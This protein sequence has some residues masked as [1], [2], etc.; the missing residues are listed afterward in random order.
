MPTPEVRPYGSWQSPITTGLIVSEA[1]ALGQIALDG[2][3]IY[4]AEM[5]PSE[6]GRNVI[7]HRT[8]DGRTFDATL[9]PFNVRTRVHEY[10]GG[11][12]TVH[13]GAI[14][15]SNFS[16]QL[17]YRQ[18]PGQTPVPIT[19]EPGIRH[20]DYVFDPARA[21]ILCVQE[22]Y[23]TGATEPVNSIAALDPLGQS[24][25]QTLVSGNDFYA[26]PRLSPD[27][28]RLAWI[29]WDHPNMPW[30][31]TQLWTA[32][33]LPDGSLGP[34]SLI[35]G[36]PTESI[37][38]P[39]WSPDGHLHFVS[40][41]TGWWNLY[42]QT[43]AGVQPLAPMQAEFGKPQWALG[44]R[45]YGFDSAGQIVC[46]YNQKG[47]WQLA[48]LDPAT[49]RVAP[50]DLP[51]QETGRGDLKVAGNR[52]VFEAGS[53]SQPMSLLSLD[54]STQELQI[55][56]TAASLTVDPSYFSYPESIEF[57]TEDGLTA[58]AFYY[59]PHNPSFTAPTGEKPPLL[60]KSHGGPTSATSTALDLAIQFWTS[61]GF[62]I[63]DVNYGGSSGYG[64][65]YR[66]RL[67]GRW[68]IVDVD[69]C[70]NAARH[71]VT[72]GL[73][74]PNRLAIDGGSA[75]GYT[76]LAALTFRDVFSAGASYYGVSDLE[77]LARD[78]HKFE[79]RYLDTLIGPYPERQ[80]LYQAR[81]PINFTGRMSCPIILFQGSEDRIVPPDQAQS[82]YQAV[83]AKGIPTAYLE[84]PGEQH[85]FRQ[86]PNIRR[87]L[88]AELYFYSR[89]F[90]FD[91]AD[92]IDP[93][94]IDNL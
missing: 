48:I 38:Q 73:A 23:T 14:F 18:D 33:F 88:E 92:P 67:N 32:P 53:P 54:L 6:A 68:G 81:S 49:N 74:D 34:A 79:S 24:P 37:F 43:A 66:Q 26:A 63:L 46:A 1:V 69:D 28:S 80:D 93:V 86:A 65:D 36:S 35:A 30:D 77:T 12:Y 59:P 51:Y 10:G 50:L 27:G 40:D 44:A 17:T 31:G 47:A 42:R 5:R 76:T 39:E 7:V 22:D 64:R 94:S 62:A 21:R 3:D 91:P 84:F 58:H 61:R 52:A 29:S 72:Q 90:G 19:S 20:A 60:L 4:W 15:F 16:D 8:P 57:P 89:V 56:K 87:A 70:V 25:P 82:M 75:G 83:R 41:R 9:P 11:A 13:Q 85:G 55:I 71:L 78:T 45:C 2:A